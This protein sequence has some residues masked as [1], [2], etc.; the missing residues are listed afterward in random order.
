MQTARQTSAEEVQRR[1]D[2]LTEK[3]EDL[4]KQMKE[5]E[6]AYHAEIAAVRDAYNKAL[7]VPQT[8]SEAAAY[9]RTVKSHAQSQVDEI[10]SRYRPIMIGS[11]RRSCGRLRRM[12]G[13]CGGLL[14]KYAN[15]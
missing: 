13:C 7:N 1:L 11:G 2:E 10:N 4:K 15:N 6:E 9:Q 8:P 12:R 3:K 14:G 5:K